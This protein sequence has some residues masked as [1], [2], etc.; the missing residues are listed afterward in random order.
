MDLQ[1]NT[2][3]KAVT[4]LEF[5][6]LEVFGNGA[7]QGK[8]DIIISF[9]Q[10]TKDKQDYQINKQFFKKTLELHSNCVSQTLSPYHLVFSFLL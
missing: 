2:S 6:L 10:H 7:V 9:L 8:A 4:S 3:G 5:L 1:K